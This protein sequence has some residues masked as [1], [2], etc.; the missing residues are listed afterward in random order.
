MNSFAK[1]VYTD[2]SDICI[3]VTQSASQGKGK[4]ILFVCTSVFWKP[5]MRQI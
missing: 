2:D 1:S 3:I 4:P 5:D